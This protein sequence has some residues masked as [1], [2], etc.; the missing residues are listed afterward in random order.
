MGKQKRAWQSPPSS[1]AGSTDSVDDPLDGRRSESGHWRAGQLLPAGNAS[2]VVFCPLGRVAGGSN[3]GEAAFADWLGKG[4]WFGHMHNVGQP[5]TPILEARTLERE[6]CAE[7][8]SIQARAPDPG[9]A[10]GLA[11]VALSHSFRRPPPTPDLRAR[12]PRHHTSPPTCR[13]SQR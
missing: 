2:A 11:C 12:P 13:A 7:P 3:E 4:R 5:L 8:V 1:L 6:A 9:T 10:V